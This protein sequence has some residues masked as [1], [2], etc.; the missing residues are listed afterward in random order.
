VNPFS[1]AV[2]LACT[3]VG[4]FQLSVAVQGAG[5]VSSSPPGIACGSGQG[6]CSNGFAAGGIVTLTQS[7]GVVGFAGWGGP[8]SGAAPTCQV[9]M[10]QAQQVTATFD[11]FLSVAIMTSA[12]ERVS[13]CALGICLLVDRFTESK[14]RVTVVDDDTGQPLGVCNA[15]TTSGFQVTQFSPISVFTTTCK[16]P[17]PLGHR[18]RLHADDMA[19]LGGTQTFVQWGPE[20]C[21]DTTSPD[22]ESGVAIEVNRSQSAIFN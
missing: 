8:C 4:Q 5:S 21:S 13:S 19:L 16:V 22:C 7:P 2:E 10:D 15:D 1:N 12:S 11:P 3:P 17:V 14:A 6:D 20:F 9:T 18:V